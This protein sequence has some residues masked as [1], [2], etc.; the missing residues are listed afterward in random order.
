MDSGK[1]GSGNLKVFVWSLFILSL[2]KE[3][4]SS[5]YFEEEGCSFPAMMMGIFKESGEGMKLSLQR[6]RETESVD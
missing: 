2:K 5:V 1:I 3:A 6:F 4:K